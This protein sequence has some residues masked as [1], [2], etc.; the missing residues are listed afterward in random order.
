[1]IT[2]SAE[3]AIQRG[4]YDPEYILDC[5]TIRLPVRDRNIRAGIMF[6]LLSTIKGLILN[7]RKEF[8]CILTVYP[9]EYDLYA[10]FVLHKIT[11]KPLVIYMHDLFSETRK[12]ARLYRLLCF[13][14]RKIFSSA[15]VILVTNERFKQY[16]LK[17]GISNVVVLPSCVD[18]HEDKEPNRISRR[19]FPTQRRKLRIVFTGGV[20]EANEDAILCFLKAI[21]KARDIEVIFATTSKKSY[22]KKVNIG[23]VPKKECYELQR[24]ADVLLLPLSFKC[25][26]PEEIECAFP[27]KA[28]EYLVAGKPI[29]AI[30]P[31]GTFCHDFVEKNRIG[32]AITEL[33]EQKILDA[34]KELKDPEKRKV[35]S[36]NAV[37]T[38]LLYDA[39]IQA[40]RLYNIIYKVI[41][42]SHTLKRSDVPN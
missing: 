17:K 6:I 23:F 35:F 24:S 40:K 3:L 8:N 10:A 7:N 29:L 21:E 31:K 12:N 32:I 5:P 1:M 15:S 16:Y 18:L 33:S 14:E 30:V 34:I 27:T 41:S 20:Y 19:I 26:Y 9:P 11:R 22:L 39:R 25:L 2:T 36:K 13:V 28:L 42:M 37:K 4:D 38:A